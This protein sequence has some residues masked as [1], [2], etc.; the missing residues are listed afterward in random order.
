MVDD[1]RVRGVGKTLLDLETPIK[2][3]D[4]P[5]KIEAVVMFLAS[6]LYFHEIY[7]PSVKYVHINLLIFWYLI[8]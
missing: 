2:Q 1:I 6:L 7:V 5:P 4:G 3:A 8:H